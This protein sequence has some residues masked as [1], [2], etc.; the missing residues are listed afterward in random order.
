MSE[1]ATVFLPLTF[2]T[3]LLGMNVAGIP[4]DHNPTGFWFVSG[5]LLGIGILSWSVL[6]RGNPIRTTQQ[7]QPGYYARI[8]R[9]LALARKSAR[10]RVL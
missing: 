1:V 8:K 6:N 4:A 3:G 9:K 10:T 5:L 2:V 7:P